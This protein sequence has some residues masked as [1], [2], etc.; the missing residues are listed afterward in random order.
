MAKA[1]LTLE[2]GTAVTI[3]G[4]AS[5]VLELLAFYGSAVPKVAH[6]GKSHKSPERLRRRHAAAER[7]AVKKLI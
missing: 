6:D 3:E 2:N 1:S 4:S 5:E 7:L